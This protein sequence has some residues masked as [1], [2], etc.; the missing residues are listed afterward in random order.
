[1]R[2]HLQTLKRYHALDFLCI[3]LSSRFHFSKAIYSKI[4][5]RYRLASYFRPRNNQTQIQVSNRLRQYLALP[6]LKPL[7]MRSEVERIGNDLKHLT[8]DMTRDVIKRFNRL[9]NYVVKYWMRFHGPNNISVN[10]A[11]HKTNN[12]SERYIPNLT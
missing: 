3:F 12:I 7:H 5:S 2:H 10:G 1:M 8:K 6:L 11:D 9:H 4:K